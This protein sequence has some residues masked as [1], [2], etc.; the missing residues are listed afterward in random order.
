M[1]VIQPDELHINR[2]TYHSRYATAAINWS[3]SPRFL[4]FNARNFSSYCLSIH[5]LGSWSCMHIPLV[6][7]SSILMYLRFIRQT[8]PFSTQLMVAD[9]LLQIQTHI[10]LNRISVIMACALVMLQ[11]S[12]FFL[13]KTEQTLPSCLGYEVSRA[14]QSPWCNILF[15]HD[16]HKSHRDFS[17]SS[18][19]HNHSMM[20]TEYHISVLWSK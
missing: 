2:K 11:R 9:T 4:C 20:W 1:I 3:Q 12:L 6:C 7:T 16:S 8:L 19:G 17:H 18:C 5:F 13:F 14:E 10:A 15:Q